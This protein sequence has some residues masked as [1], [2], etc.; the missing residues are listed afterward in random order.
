MLA[1]YPAFVRLYDL[2]VR[3]GDDLRPL[4]WSERRL[5]LE[6]LMPRLDPDRF[7]LSQLVAAATLGELAAG[8]AN[9][10]NQPVA[11]MLTNTRIANRVLRFVEGLFAAA[12]PQIAQGRTISYA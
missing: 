8:M 11:E 10:L 2:L 6:A 5:H 7:D 1:D 4:A 12:D 9:D 3:E